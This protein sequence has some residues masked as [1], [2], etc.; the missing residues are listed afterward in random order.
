VSVALLVT[1]N[2]LSC[3]GQTRAEGGD[4]GTPPASG[5]GGNRT[6]GGDGGTGP[7]DAGADVNASPPPLVEPLVPIDANLDTCIRTTVEPISVAAP[8]TYPVALPDGATVSPP[9][10]VEYTAGDK[11]MY[12]VVQNDSATCDRGWHFINNQTQIEICGSTCDIISSDPGAQLELMF[13][14]KSPLIQ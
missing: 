8:C 10:N 4:G 11:R 1:A 5:T 7:S 3:G 2:S 6:V 12:I 9:L 14:C 13:G